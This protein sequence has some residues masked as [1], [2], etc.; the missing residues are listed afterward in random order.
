MK[1]ITKVEEYISIFFFTLIFLLMLMGIINRYIFKL[2]L[3]WNLELSRYSFVWLCFFGLGYVRTLDG[4]LKL[5]A[6]Y[7]KVSKNVHRYVRRIIWWFKKLL[8]IY[9]LLQLIY[10]GIEISIKSSRFK[11]QALQI[12]QSFLYISVSVGALLYLITEILLSF[13]EYRESNLSKP[14]ELL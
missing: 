13:Q 1:F 12:P 9:F 3:Y 7:N 11:S 4:H 2:P 8:T 14:G 6:L 10:L 5:D